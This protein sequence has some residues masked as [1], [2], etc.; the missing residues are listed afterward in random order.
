MI[1]TVWE[2]WG[3]DTWGP[4]TW[5]TATSTFNPAWAVNANQLVGYYGEHE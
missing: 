4:D 1:D 2:W 5:G 3:T